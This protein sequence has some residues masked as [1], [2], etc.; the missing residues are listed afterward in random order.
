L[1]NL[2]TWV[3]HK[4]NVRETKVLVQCIM[5]I[6]ACFMTCLALKQC[7]DMH[8]ICPKSNGASVC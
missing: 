1:S 3:Y 7:L 6:L 2:Y 5:A 8:V 4:T